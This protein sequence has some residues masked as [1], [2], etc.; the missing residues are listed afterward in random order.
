M[1]DGCMDML[2]LLIQYGAY[3]DFRTKSGKTA[4]HNV[5][6]I[7]KDKALKVFFITSYSFLKL[8]LLWKLNG[9]GAPH[10]FAFKWHAQII[11]IA[12]LSM[13]LIYTIT[14]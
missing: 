13:N 4:L 2:T 7:G 3:L 12:R 10:S 14:L 6:I 1:L 8:L 11:E 5:A 9:I